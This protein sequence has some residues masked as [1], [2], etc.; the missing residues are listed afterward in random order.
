MPCG[1]AREHS[2]LATRVHCNPESGIDFAPVQIAELD[3]PP[4]KPGLRTLPTA[5]IQMPASAIIRQ[6]PVTGRWPH[7]AREGMLRAR[8]QLVGTRAG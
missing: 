4:F 2:I 5:V 1:T 7:S 3:N 6:L 8:G